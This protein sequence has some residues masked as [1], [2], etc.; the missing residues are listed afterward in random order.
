MQYCASGVSTFRCEFTV[1]KRRDAVRGFTIPTIKR[2]F[3]FFN[4]FGSIFFAAYTGLGCPVESFGGEVS[5]SVGVYS[6]CSF[7]L[8][9][10]SL[11]SVPRDPKLNLAEAELNC[12]LKG[13]FIQ[14]APK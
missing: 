1:G 6:M 5:E 12:S 7:L 10:N 11:T 4:I 14:K 9:L 3:F 13:Q 2:F 8:R